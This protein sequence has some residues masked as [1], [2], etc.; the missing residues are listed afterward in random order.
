MRVRWGNN[1][2]KIGG[3]ILYYNALNYK[4]FHQ[5]IIIT[6]LC[7]DALVEFLFF[8]I[9]N[10]NPVY[11]TLKLSI[12]VCVFLGVRLFLFLDFIIYI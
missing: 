2:P 12:T 7:V 8:Y 10:S 1:I 5:Y 4:I 11:Y 3:L 6:L 9:I